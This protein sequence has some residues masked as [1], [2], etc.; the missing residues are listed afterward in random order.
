M[1]FLFRKCVGT[2]NYHTRL[3]N[4]RLKL[5]YGSTVLTVGGIDYLALDVVAGELRL[6]P[7]GNGSGGHCLAHHADVECGS[8]QLAAHLVDKQDME[9][10]YS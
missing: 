9:G 2:H 7:W 1:P 6:L 10:T 8:D 4:T 3:I 5:N